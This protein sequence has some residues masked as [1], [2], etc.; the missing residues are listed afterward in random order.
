MYLVLIYRSFYNYLFQY[1]A[2]KLQNKF[3]LNS[4]ILFISFFNS[5]CSSSNNKRLSTI[6]FYFSFF[7]FL[8]F[9]IKNSSGFRLKPSITTYKSF[10]KFAVLLFSINKTNLIPVVFLDVFLIDCNFVFP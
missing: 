7:D 9:L 2:L 6:K 4:C 3:L 5:V 10:E 1:L 8:F